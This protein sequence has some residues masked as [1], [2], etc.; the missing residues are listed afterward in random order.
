MVSHLTNQTNHQG[1]PIDLKV[2]ANVKYCPFSSLNSPK[3]QTSYQLHLTCSKPM[4]KPH[5][6]SSRRQHVSTCRMTLPRTQTLTPHGNSSTQCLSKTNHR[7]L[8]L[9]K[10]AKTSPSRMLK[11]V[12]LVLHEC[13]VLQDSSRRAHLPIVA[14]RLSSLVPIEQ[15]R[16]VLTQGA[17]AE[18]SKERLWFRT[19]AQ[20]HPRFSTLI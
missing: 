20:F 16:P 13:Q 9:G 10:P 7:Q 6:S 18:D 15:E 1:L 2:A 17:P 5:H 8:S 11:E 3:D 14:L 12:D 4:G 19:S